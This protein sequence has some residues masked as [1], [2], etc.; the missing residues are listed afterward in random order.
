MDGRYVDAV[1]PPIAFGDRTRGARAPILVGRRGICEEIPEARV[2]EFSRPT[3]LLIESG[4]GARGSQ[5]TRLDLGL[6]KSG[7]QSWCDRRFAV[8]LFHVVV[9]E[10]LRPAT[11]LN[12]FPRSALGT[13][14][15]QDALVA[16]VDA[17]SRHFGLPLESS[18]IQA[19]VTANFTKLARGHK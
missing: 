6:M 1:L 11:F 17:C 5:P 15:N 9:H 2:S 7:H 19:A 12:R 13:A 18:L 8:L 16:A 4:R 3:Y 14:A 10:S